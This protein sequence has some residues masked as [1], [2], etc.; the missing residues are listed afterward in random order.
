VSPFDA[1]ARG[2]RGCR[3][4]TLPKPA[5]YCTPRRRGDCEVRSAE[6]TPS[7]EGRAA[8]GGEIA[9]SRRSLQRR[10]NDGERETTAGQSPTARCVRSLLIGRNCC[11]Q[12][13]GIS[14]PAM[15]PAHPR[16]GRS[17]AGPPFPDAIAGRRVGRPWQPGRACRGGGPSRAGLPE[18]GGTRRASNWLGASPCRGGSAAGFAAGWPASGRLADCAGST[19]ILPKQDFANRDPPA[20][21]PCRAGRWARFSGTLAGAKFRASENFTARRTCKKDTRNSNALNDGIKIAVCH[22]TPLRATLGTPT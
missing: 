5:P 11:W 18:D 16:G 20:L 12:N 2:G 21:L 6:A 19:L 17:Q 4:P 9:A 7:M 13:D 3:C 8:P 1:G 10:C 14:S 15:P 22:D